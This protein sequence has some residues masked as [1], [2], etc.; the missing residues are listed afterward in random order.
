MLVDK[1]YP[2]LA[3]F[4]SDEHYHPDVI[5][6]GHGLDVVELV[7]EAFGTEGLFH[8]SFETEGGAFFKLD[9]IYEN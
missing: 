7:L 2:F 3:R 9:R 1:S 5:L 8:K 6:V 4:R